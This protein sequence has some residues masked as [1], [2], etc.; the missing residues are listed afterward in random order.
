MLISGL[1]IIIETASALTFCSHGADKM[2]RWKHAVSASPQN[3]L[4]KNPPPA[5]PC[6]ASPADGFSLFAD[7]L[8]SPLSFGPERITRKDVPQKNALNSALKGV[9]KLCVQLRQRLT[10]L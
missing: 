1:F 10:G 4:P 8:A 9:C 7:R 5:T 2:H 3:T 6:Q